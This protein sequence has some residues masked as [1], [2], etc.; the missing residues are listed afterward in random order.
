ME[1]Y[2]QKISGS[3]KALTKRKFLKAIAFCKEDAELCPQS[4]EVKL[5]KEEI[6]ARQKA[7]SPKRKR[8]KRLVVGS[9][10]FV[11]ILFVLFL[12]YMSL[13]DSNQRHFRLAQQYLESR[14]LE[15]AR[16][17]L[18]KCG[19][20][21][22]PDRHAFVKKLDAAEVELLVDQA[23][24]FAREEAYEDAINALK[25]AGKLSKGTGKYEARIRQLSE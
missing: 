14:Q 20:L 24:E 19:S 23:N 2:K 16:Y 3:R 15:Q 22:V 13:R 18:S 4:P 6:A 8:Y 17:E 11:S 25:Q 10:I 1:R 7:A 21:G 9:V 5:L 12:S